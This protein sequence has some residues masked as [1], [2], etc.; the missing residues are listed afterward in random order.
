MIV[1][2]DSAGFHVDKELFAVPAHQSWLCHLTFTFLYTYKPS[3]PVSFLSLVV[4]LVSCHVN[5]RISSF[6]M[7]TVVASPS[8]LS[9]IPSTSKRPA[10]SP[11]SSQPV[12][13]PRQSSSSP[14][15]EDEAASD[16]D[17]DEEA[18]AKLAR[19]EAR[20]SL[21]PL[22]IGEARF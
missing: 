11:S 18:L 16:E 21:L 4:T 7:A 17:L 15:D 20:V 12:K 14:R 10:P 9:P 13:R 19:K 3:F 1:R 6:T 8:S 2:F 22:S 5:T